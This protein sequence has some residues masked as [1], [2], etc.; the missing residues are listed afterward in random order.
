MFCQHPKLKCPWKDFQMCF[1]LDYGSMQTL[2]Q[3]ESFPTIGAL[4][5]ECRQKECFIQKWSVGPRS[6]QKLHR[7]NVQ[8]STMQQAKQN[9]L[10]HK[11]EWENR[12]TT[13]HYKSLSENVH[14]PN[15]LSHYLTFP[16]KH[17]ANA[18]GSLWPQT[19]LEW[20]GWMTSLSW[21]FS[22]S[23]GHGKSQR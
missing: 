14:L 3:H 12:W 17:Y 5:R 15:P 8:G 6:W 16:V 19:S 22:C 1:S 4:E 13:G 2:Q 7:D 21:E 11:Q 9:E 20:A 10:G 23:L 18:Y